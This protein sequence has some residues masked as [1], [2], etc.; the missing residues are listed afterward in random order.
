MPGPRILE[1]VVMATADN[2]DV[3]APAMFVDTHGLITENVTLSQ[4][5]TT[6]SQY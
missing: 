5:P 1:P 3:D 2:T 6:L 4:A